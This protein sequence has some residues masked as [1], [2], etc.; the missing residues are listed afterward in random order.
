MLCK[1]VDNYQCFIG[2]YRQDE[3]FLGPFEPRG[4]GPMSLCNGRKCLSLNT[5]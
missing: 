4:E 1:L 2:L 3:G 5:A